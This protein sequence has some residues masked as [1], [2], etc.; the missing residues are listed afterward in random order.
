L[1]RELRTLTHWLQKDVLHLAGPSLAIR[2]ELYDF[3]VA[4]WQAR[5]HWDEPRLRPV[6]I[7][8]QNQRD[9]LLAFAG[10]LDKKLSVIAQA[11]GVGEALV[12]QA[13]LLHGLPKTSRAYWQGWNRLRGPLGRAFDVVQIRVTNPTLPQAINA[14]Y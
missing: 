2:R 8:L 4:Q 10:V 9:S 13:C 5:E 7:A 3:I 12:R 14:R 1:V 11:R 6:R